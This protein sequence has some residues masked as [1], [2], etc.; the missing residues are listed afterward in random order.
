MARSLTT[1]LVV[2]A[3]GT[4]ISCCAEAQMKRGT[5]GF[6][7][8][9]RV[10]T[11]RTVNNGDFELS[12]NMGLH[13]E[14]MLTTSLNQRTGSDVED[15]WYDKVYNEAELDY[16]FNDKVD[17]TFSANEDWNKDTM[18]TLGKSLLN[19]NFGGLLH[20][21]PT[22]SMSFGGGLEHTYDTRFDNVDKGTTAKGE[23]EYSGTPVRS[24]RK[25]RTRVSTESRS[26]GT[27]ASIW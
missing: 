2:V 6:E 4:V 1:I 23:F 19:T 20:Y 27:S 9:D 10:L 17:V 24:N 11:W 25:L 7:R 14:S 13:L 21:S 26:R 18:N 3:A 22:K 12:G 5:V 16:V 15:R 8:N